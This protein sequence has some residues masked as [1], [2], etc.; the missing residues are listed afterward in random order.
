MAA[1]YHWS[2]DSTCLY[3]TAMET[4]D[5]DPLAIINAAEKLESLKA[6]VETTPLER[7]HE[8]ETGDWLVKVAVENGLAHTQVRKLVNFGAILLPPDY[9]LYAVPSK[10][11]GNY[12]I[13][14]ASTTDNSYAYVVGQFTKSSF[15]FA[16]RRQAEEAIGG[17]KI[18]S[19]IVSIGY[20]ET[21]SLSKDSGTYYLTGIDYRLSIPSSFFR[22]ANGGVLAHF[23]SLLYSCGVDFGEFWEDSSLQIS[24][25]IGGNPASAIFSLFSTRG[26]RQFPILDIRLFFTS[27]GSEKAAQVQ[28]ASPGSMRIKLHNGNVYNV[29]SYSLVQNAK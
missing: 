20:D 4:P 9:D 27:G 23:E 17:Q 8:V 19:Q 5:S 13:Y 1:F 2:Y 14:L 12:D 3:K 25:G 29:A 11:V 18:P 16:S 7:M 15:S 22:K 26:E 28:I 10:P 6:A 21:T 24:S